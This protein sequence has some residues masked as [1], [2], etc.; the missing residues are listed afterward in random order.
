MG[1]NNIA[2]R[3]YFKIKEGKIAITINIADKDKFQNM[4]KNCKSTNEYVNI[5]GVSKIDI[6]FSEFT[7]KLRKI[8]TSERTF[9]GSKVKNWNLY[10]EDSNS[11]YV[12][13]M[14]YNSYD[15]Q[16][17][18]NSLSSIKGDIGDI[19]IRPYLFNGKAG[20]SIYHGGE[21]LSWKFSK[22]EQPPLETKKTLADD[23][24]TIIDDIDDKT[25]KPRINDKKRMAWLMEL[26]LNIN[27]KIG[28]DK[29]VSGTPNEHED[30]NDVTD[31]SQPF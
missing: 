23:G 17:L 10:F 8:E 13:S 12:C 21:K 27:D 15:I 9:N 7:G 18:I 16:G 19:T 22:E 5:N 25:G 28:A 20:F 31:D 4:I 6:N 14:P 3:Q 24:K 11:T 2:P 1:F 26:I 30:D 29:Y